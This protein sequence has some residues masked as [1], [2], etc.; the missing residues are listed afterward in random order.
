[1]QKATLLESAG[2]QPDHDRKPDRRQQK[3]QGSTGQAAIGA[4]CLNG[5]FGFRNNPCS[6]FP[7]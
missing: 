5:S 2:D 4:R 6:T 7:R 1:L 3:V